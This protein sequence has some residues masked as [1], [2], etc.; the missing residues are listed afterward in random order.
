MGVGT[1]P[2]A[3]APPPPREVNPAAAAAAAVAARGAAKLAAPPTWLSGLELWREKMGAICDREAA[4]LGLA[5]GGGRAA[6][7]QRAGWWGAAGTLLSVR[8]RRQLGANTLLSLAFAYTCE[9]V[10]GWP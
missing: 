1:T 2:S 3:P 8:I 6:G 7:G 10:G 4:W 5:R 9:V